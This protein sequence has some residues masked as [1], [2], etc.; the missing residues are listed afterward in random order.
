MSGVPRHLVVR[1]PP[2]A[3]PDDLVDREPP[4]HIAQREDVIQA[5]VRHEDHVGVGAGGDGGEGPAGA[6]G[7]EVGHVP[8]PFG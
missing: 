2:P 5:G 8:G 6:R 7:E 1:H 4:P 3:G